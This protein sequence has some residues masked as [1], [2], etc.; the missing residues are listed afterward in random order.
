M[1][2]CFL[3]IGGGEFIFVALA[4]L[5]LFG[6]SKIP[7]LARM[8]GKGMNEFKK[9]TDD[10]KREFNDSTGGIVDDIKKSQE[11]INREVREIGN[12][13]T[14]ISDYDSYEDDEYLQEGEDA[15][16]IEDAHKSEANEASIEDKKKESNPSKQ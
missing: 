6:S 16:E 3:G 13:V 1:S 8:F 14:D 12:S 5:L 15:S 2:L 7:E 4:V 9:A 10:I 11:E